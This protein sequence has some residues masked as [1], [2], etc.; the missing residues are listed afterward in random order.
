[1]K[2]LTSHFGFQTLPYT[3]EIATRDHFSHRDLDGA[4]QALVRTIEKKM[5]GGL[6]APA[7]CGKTNVLRR[8]NDELPEARYRVR[9]LKVTGLSKRDMCREI[10]SAL[11][12]EPAGSYPMLVRRVQ[13]YLQSTLEVEG[14]RPVLLIDEAHELRPD[15]LAMLRILTNFE[16]DSKLVVSVILA[17]QPPLRDLLQRADLES[18]ARRLAHIATLGPLSKADALAYLKHRC[19]V[20][21]NR[22]FPF[23]ARSTEA[24]FEIA[25]G[26]LRATDRLALASLEVAFDDGAKAVDPNHVAAARTRL[27][28]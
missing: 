22:K 2:D 3:R 13:E 15:V 23:D 21:G 10:C 17:G 26:N 27:W 16:M 5:S 11:G 24:V 18:V 14:L 4:V 20:A 7:G 12:T 1:M 19:H 8:V 6:L 25:R 9:Y 28:P